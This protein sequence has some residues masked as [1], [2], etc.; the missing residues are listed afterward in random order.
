MLN[1][2]ET[3]FARTLAV[4]LRTLRLHHALSQ[5]DL[6]RRAGVSRTAVHH[7]ERGTHLPRPSTLRQLA[8]ALHV[9][10]TRLTTDE[11]E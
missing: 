3:Q 8:R 5:Q 4:R 9:N 6:A 11:G 7:I 2:A 10:V 1:T